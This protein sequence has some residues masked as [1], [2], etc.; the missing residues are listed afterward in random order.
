[1]EGLKMIIIKAWRRADKIGRPTRWE[2]YGNPSPADV[3][4]EVE[5][6]KSQGFKAVIVVYENVL[7]TY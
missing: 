2:M 4:Y 1:M 5:A 3:R 7:K 6:F